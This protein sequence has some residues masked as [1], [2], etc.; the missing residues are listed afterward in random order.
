MPNQKATL[1]SPLMDH[2]PAGVLSGF[3]AMCIRQHSKVETLTDWS[4]AAEACW[5]IECYLFGGKDPELVCEAESWAILSA[6]GEFL[7]LLERG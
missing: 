2:L 4:L 3:S 5:D 7:K 6:H 1:V